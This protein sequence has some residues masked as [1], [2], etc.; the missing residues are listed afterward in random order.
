M[1]SEA[2]GHITELRSDNHV[3]FMHI[4]EPGIGTIYL[5]NE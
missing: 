3:L 5:L 2:D 4:V 1:K